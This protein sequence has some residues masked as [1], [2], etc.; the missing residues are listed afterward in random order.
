MSDIDP[1]ILELAKRDYGEHC[2]LVRRTE[3][4]YTF[5]CGPKSYCNISRFLAEK[6]LEVTAKEIRVRW[7]EWD[8][9]QRMDFASNWWAKRTWTP[10]DT[11]ILEIIMADGDDRIW[12]SCAQAFLKHP[13]RDRAITFL[14]GCVL[15]WKGD[16]APLNYFQVLGMAK[17]QRAV[18]AIL[19][20]YE[21]HKGEVAREAEIGIP[22]SLSFGPIPYFPYLS[23]AGALFAITGSPEYEQAIRKYFDHPREQVRWWAEHALGIEGPTTAKRNAEYRNQREHR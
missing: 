16:H 2:E 10:D 7:V 23:A 22:E 15:N 8:E 19:P 17:D 18:A 20:W 14:V 12:H 21:R 11:K 5:K 6:A 1:E 13:D 3:W 4:S 9:R